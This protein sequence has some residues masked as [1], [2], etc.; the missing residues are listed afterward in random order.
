MGTPHR[1][2]D[3]AYWMDFLARALYSAQ[4][5]MGTNKKLLPGLKKN[6]KT[7]SDISRQFTDRGRDL[8]I[9]TFY[10]RE[11]MDYT[12]VLVS[13]SLILESEIHLNA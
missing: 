6:S 13:T 10:E 12:N 8:Q 1:G 4:F 5:G 2:A 9:R 11:K 7:L 3:V